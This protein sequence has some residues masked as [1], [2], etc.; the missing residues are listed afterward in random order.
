MSDN[1]C[2][3]MKE[4][5]AEIGISHLIN[6]KQATAFVFLLRSFQYKSGT[7]FASFIYNK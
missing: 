2:P 6:R 4:T 1:Y 3:S 7:M 5:A